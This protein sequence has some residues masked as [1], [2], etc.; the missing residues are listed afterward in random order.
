ISASLGLLPACHLPSEALASV[1]AS[2]V[3]RSMFLFQRV[4]FSLRLVLSI[5]GFLVDIKINRITHSNL[6]L[7]PLLR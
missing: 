2:K 1:I 4:L 3:R 6:S 7:R 5:L